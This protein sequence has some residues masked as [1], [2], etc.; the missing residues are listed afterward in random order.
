MTICFSS[1]IADDSQSKLLNHEKQTTDNSETG[2]EI[3]AFL[4]L[5]SDFRIFHRK[6]ESPWLF[7]FR[8]LDIKD[9]FINESA[10]GF[11]NDGSDKE[12]TKKT[13]LYFNY[14]FN[15]LDDGSFYLSGA[16]YNSVL[17]IEC[18]P[19]SDSESST[20]IYFGGGY[21]GRWRNGFGYKIGMLMSP[22]VN[23]KLDTSTCSI[24]SNGDFDLNASLT[25]VF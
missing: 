10:A 21:Q 13:G 25:F 8:Y 11:P 9:D 4:I 2:I 5:G 3:G 16:L 15:H 22:F 24:E 17:K 23:F 18:E 14:L 12:Y 1:A 7:G 20:S 6:A 19:E